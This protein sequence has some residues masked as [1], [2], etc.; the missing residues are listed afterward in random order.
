MLDNP[1]TTYFTGFKILDPSFVQE[2]SLAEYSRVS[3]VPERNLSIVDALNKRF[4][5]NESIAFKKSSGT[6]S[7]FSLNN[8]QVHERTFSEIEKSIESIVIDVKI[9]GS[10]TSF[11]PNTFKRVR[12]HFGVTD[13]TIKMSVDPILNREQIWKSNKL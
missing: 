11:L 12:S 7:K 2:I 4:S 10:I 3:D 1:L 13:S 5:T 6:N 9:N 8:S